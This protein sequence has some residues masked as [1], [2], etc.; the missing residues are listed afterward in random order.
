MREKVPTYTRMDVRWFKQQQ[1]NAGVTAEDIAKL[2][3]RD[4]S[5]V[6]HIYKGERRMSLE[7]AQAFSE[8]LSVPL[9]DVLRH[10]GRLE[11]SQRNDTTL[12]IFED[13]DVAPL[14]GQTSGGERV[15]RIAEALGG[16]K[17][18][19][20]VWAVR[21]PSMILGGF[22]LGDRIL[23]DT[24]QSELCRTGDVVVANRFNQRS[25]SVE[26]LLRRFEPPVLVAASADSDD[27]RV[28]V[29]DGTNVAIRGKVVA[30][31]RG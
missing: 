11:N 4:R 1:K 8:A 12:Q 26:C 20:D 9:E 27:Q 31:W 2:M 21:R 25:N 30:S 6:S 5:A 14:F 18:G 10:A 19:I 22:L 7:W 28:V 13:G 23:L 15:R 29:V 16:D 24:N 17:P 3:G